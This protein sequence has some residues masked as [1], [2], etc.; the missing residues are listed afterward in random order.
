MNRIQNNIITILRNPRIGCEFAVWLFKKKLLKQEPIKKIRNDISVGD[1]SGFSEYVA[2]DNFIHDNE[3]AFFSNL[4]FEEGDI[5]DI[6]ANL[7]VLSIMFAQMCPDR[8]IYS[9]EPNPSTYKALLGNIQ[10]NRTS[11]VKAFELAMSNYEGTVQFITDPVSRGTASIAYEADQKSTHVGCTTLDIFVS[12]ENI[13]NISLLKVDVE[14]YETLVFRGGI[15]TLREL[16]PKCIYFEVCP[17]I[18]K[19]AGFP[20]DEPAKILMD[21]GYNLCRLCSDGSLTPSSPKEIAG[22]AYENWVAIDD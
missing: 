17:P 7:G 9:I 22:L 3:F 4:D 14:G 10:R 2:I 8:T 18:T 12:K 20:A 6:G 5:I 19:R 16:R 1:F 15:K 21:A 11:N 13:E